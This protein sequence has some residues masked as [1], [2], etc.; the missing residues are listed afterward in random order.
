LPETGLVTKW[1]RVEINAPGRCLNS[2]PGTA[3]LRNTGVPTS[4][5]PANHFDAAWSPA[6]LALARPVDETVV[7]PLPRALEAQLTDIDRDLA[8][9]PEMRLQ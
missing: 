3:A 7:D 2:Q 6:L 8:R 9:F 4:R 1:L 5:F